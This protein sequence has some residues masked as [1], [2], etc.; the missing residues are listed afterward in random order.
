MG[1]KTAAMSLGQDFYPAQLSELLR[2]SVFSG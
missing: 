1:V 2:F